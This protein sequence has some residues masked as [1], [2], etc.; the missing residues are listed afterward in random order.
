MKNF[1]LIS[2]FVLSLAV[3]QLSSCS[4]DDDSGSGGGDAPAGKVTAK[5][6]GQDFESFGSGA[7]SGGVFTVT[8]NSAVLNGI[9]LNGNAI[10]ITIL[11]NNLQEQAYDM[12]D[13]NAIT[14]T[15]A[16]TRVDTN[17]PFNP[18]SYAAPYMNSGD[19]GTITITELTDTNVKGT[20]EFS[21]RNQAD[22]TDIVEITD[23]SFNLEISGS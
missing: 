12:D 19:V 1:K 8:P 2:I 9:D 4:S 22:D 17:D 18:D 7:Q 5:I 13:A 15:G 23:G 3:M 21:P 6:D 16:Y 14:V 20:F 11:T 10:V